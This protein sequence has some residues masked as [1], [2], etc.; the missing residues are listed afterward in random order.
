M[1]EPSTRLSEVSLRALPIAP[2]TELLRGARGIKLDN[3][4]LQHKK[5]VQNFLAASEREQHDVVDRCGVYI[6]LPDTSFAYTGEDRL[7]HL[8]NP[9]TLM[10]V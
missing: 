9:L 6:V 2:L 10:S 1:T 7:L 3:M 4:S 5:I 8:R